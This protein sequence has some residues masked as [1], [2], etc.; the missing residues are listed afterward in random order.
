MNF[1]DPDGHPAV[2][3]VEP[4]RQYV[5]YYCGSRPGSYWNLCQHEDVHVCCHGNCCLTRCKQAEVWLALML[6]SSRVLTPPAHQVWPCIFPLPLFPYLSF[7]LLFLSLRFLSSP[8]P[9]PPRP[10]SLSIC[11]PLTSCSSFPSISLPPYPFS[12]PSFLI[13]C[14]IQSGSLCHAVL[15]WAHMRLRIHMCVFVCEFLLR[16][17]AVGH[18]W[19][20]TLELLFWASGPF[21]YSEA[22]SR[23]PPSIIVPIH[24]SLHHSPC[25]LSGLIPILSFFLLNA[26][27][28]L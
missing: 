14:I 4:L 20:M 24:H 7:S 16:L 8:L 27:P 6:V 17:Q 28:P 26:F 11:P 18:A 25:F 12:W 2:W 1:G 22:N 10:D 23:P 13:G 19:L 21:L 15:E 9:A 5:D 3:D